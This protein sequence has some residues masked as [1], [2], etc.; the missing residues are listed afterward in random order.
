MDYR[1]TSGD[2]PDHLRARLRQRAEQ[3]YLMTVW[4]AISTLLAMATAALLAL[5]QG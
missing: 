2:Q 3:R 1:G 5:S 4:G